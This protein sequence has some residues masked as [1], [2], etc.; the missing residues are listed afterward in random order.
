MRRLALIGLLVLAA[1]GCGSDF[2]GPPKRPGTHGFRAHATVRRGEKTVEEFELAVRGNA[3]RKEKGTAVLLWDGDAKTSTLLDTA[4]RT[5]K[6]RP[7]TALDEA[8]PGHPLHAGFSEKEEAGRRQIDNYHREADAILAGHVCWLWRFEDRPDD[9]TSPSTTL[10]TAPD[11]DRLV[12]R[13]DREK[14]GD[15]DA[16]L[17][18]ELTNVRIG[19]DPEL[20]RI[21]ADYRR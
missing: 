5:A 11:L 4:A 2:F 14:P 13:V 7:F 18:S 20:F 15:P 6:A 9:P 17:T 16:T 12:L 21:P 10:W 19:A 1:T 3:R 8:L